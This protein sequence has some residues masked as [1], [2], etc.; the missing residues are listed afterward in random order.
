MQVKC[1]HI[2]IPYTRWLNPSYMHLIIWTHCQVIC[3]YKCRSSTNTLQVIVCRWHTQIH[4]QPSGWAELHID[5]SWQHL[6]EWKLHGFTQSVCLY[7]PC[8]GHRCRRPAPGCSPRWGYHGVQLLSRP[9]WR[10]CSWCS[11][12]PAAGEGPPAPRARSPLYK[13]QRCVDKDELRLWLAAAEMLKGDWEIKMVLEE[14][15]EGGSEGREG[16]E[17]D[18]Q[19]DLDGCEPEL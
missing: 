10:C 18:K 11:T 5:Y 9:G 6:K 8:T 3:N 16:V 17:E 14:S 1:M 13:G 4:T 15:V 19:K 2:H 7:R 12:S